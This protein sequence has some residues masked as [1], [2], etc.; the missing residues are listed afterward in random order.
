MAEDK[1]D[2]DVDAGVDANVV[3]PI[4]ITV[5]ALGEEVVIPSFVVALSPVLQAA[6]KKG[7]DNKEPMK[8][9]YSASAIREMIS[10]YSP[11]IDD[12]LQLPGKDGDWFLSGSFLDESGRIMLSETKINRVKMPNSAGK[13]RLMMKYKD[14]VGILSYLVRID[15]KGAEFTLWLRRQSMRIKVEGMMHS[16]FSKSNLIIYSLRVGLR[17]LFEKSILGDE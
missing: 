14:V 17:A 12:Y 4:D 16:T 8:L 10:R 13:P 3:E 6:L 1:N 7:W 9:P 2:L 15:R 5:D 11:S